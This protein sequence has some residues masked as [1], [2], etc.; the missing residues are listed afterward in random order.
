MVRDLARVHL[1]TLFATAC[2]LFCLGVHAQSA[3]SATCSTAA[4]S[5]SDLLDEVHTI[6]AAT[7]AVP[8]ECSFD[9]SLAG[10]YQ[11]TLTDLGVVPGS[12]PPQPALMT[13]IKLAVTGGNTVVGTPI[14][15]T[16][17]SNTSGNPQTGSMTFNAAV[18]SYVIHVVGMPGGPGSGPVG[19]QVTPAGST[20]LLASFSPTL[21]LPPTALPTNESTLDDSFT[22]SSS[23]QYTIALTDLQF[24]QALTAAVLL[25]T[26]GN[27]V[28]V[29]SPPLSNANP[30]VTVN[31]QQGMTY[32]ILGVGQSDPTVNAGLFSASVTPTTAGALPVYSKVVSVGAVTSLGSAAL[33]GGGTY[34]LGLADLGYPTALTG[35][36]AVVTA[37]GLAAA[38][39]TAAGNSTPFTS[40]TSTYQVFAL[41][42]TTGNGSY[43]ASLAP[44]GGGAPV[45]S[46][47][48]AVAATG[49]G[50]ASAF[51]F[52]TTVV[53]AG[54][55]AFDLADFAFP[56]AFASLRSVVVQNGAIV[57][58]PLAVPGTEN[59][60]LASGSASLLVFAQAATAGSLFGVDLTATGGNPLFATTQ[61]VGQLFSGRQVSITAAGNYAVIV[62]DVGFPAP[63]STFA[64]VV[65]RGASQI[66][67]IYGGGT[68]SFAATPGNY[69]INF[70]A[71]PGGT[72]QAGTY[73]MSVAP[74]P[75]VTLQSSATTVVSGGTVTLS[76]TSQNVTS[77]TASGG[78]WTGSQGP[79]GTITSPTLSG[80]TTFTLTCTGGGATAT[81]SVTVKLADPP[82]K[83]SGGGGALSL[84]GL[85]GLLGAL[86]TRVSTGPGRA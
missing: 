80:T 15:L 21:A 26:D 73:A 36:R 6:A 30:S 13:T 49:G 79:N 42:S 28:L 12:S 8:V 84:W 32:R 82:A 9:V 18:G 52:D 75:A 68:F 53:T 37:N 34:V 5:S 17:A 16:S 66:G 2:A 86:L 25:V 27:A 50:A 74:A 58:Q 48:R 55:Y 20:T 51:N 1:R 62:S 61:G 71:Q 77:C 38:S 56:S 14:T 45:L 83:S 3:P 24:P 22:I 35:L 11:I 78:G 43:A 59:L 10:S 54:T 65:T 41:P 57:G 69:F 31:L 19:I 40:T 70:I 85:L 81:S 47:A 76:W 7:Q 72:D 46:T 4:A 63:L 44:Q 60:T 29:T 33:T 64:V 39:L 67:S 23:G